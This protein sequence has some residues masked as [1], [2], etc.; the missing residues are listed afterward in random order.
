MSDD[1]SAEFTA[2]AE[3]GASALPAS[4]GKQTQANRKMNDDLLKAIND[5]KQIA[6]GDS[7]PAAAAA[8]SDEEAPPEALVDH[9]G[10][11]VTAD[12]R[13]G[14]RGAVVDDDS[15]DDGG[16]S[17][18]SGGGGGGGRASGPGA[19]SGAHGGDSDSDSDFGP[20][21]PSTSSSEDDEPALPLPVSHEAVIPGHTRAVSAIKC[22]P[23]GARIV[24][25]GFDENLRMCAPADAALESRVQYCNTLTMYDFAGMTS[26]LRAFRELQPQE[27]AYISDISWSITGDSYLCAPS[28]VTR[29]ALPQRVFVTFCAGTP[30]RSCTAAMERPS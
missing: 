1:E 7:A 12:F 4:F 24:T 19:K 14:K 3:D 9:R 30:S 22:D 25:G 21:L 13:A 28:Y 8:N 15:D 26:A 27:G 16:S 17:S 20:A 29:H 6:R 10:G 5:M 2:V 23:S 18:S 11:R